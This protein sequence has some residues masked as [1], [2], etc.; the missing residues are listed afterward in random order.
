MGVV[1]RGEQNK[2]VGGLAGLVAGANGQA[3]EH[4]LHDAPWDAEALNQR[5]L[6]RWKTHPYLGPHAQGVLIVDATGDPK[7]GRC[8]VL[9]AQQYLGKLGH[10]ATGVAAEDNQ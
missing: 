1:R 4:V 8:I 6:T 2:A 5:R 7:R 3:L 10:L 9:A